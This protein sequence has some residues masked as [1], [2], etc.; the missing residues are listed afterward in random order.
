MGDM[1]D[2][3]RVLVRKTTR[4]RRLGRTR[5]RWKDN[6]K[7]DIQD[8]KWE[9]GALTGLISLRTGTGGELW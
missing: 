6:S 9:R 2:T 7:M 1:R 8:A 4:K 5:R 3:Y